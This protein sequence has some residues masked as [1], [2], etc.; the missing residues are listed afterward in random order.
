MEA[1]AHCAVSAANRLE[2]KRILAAY[3]KE[4]FVMR[5]KD[6][7]ANKKDSRFKY[8]Y[9]DGCPFYLLPRAPDHYRNADESFC[10]Q[11]WG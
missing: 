1:S 7:R 9:L 8:I 3:G 10:L 2:R 6:I 4:T 11:A 5:W